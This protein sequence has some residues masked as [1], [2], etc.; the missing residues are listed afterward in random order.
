MGL[1][2]GQLVRYFHQL[3]IP[4]NQVAVA[5]ALVIQVPEVY[6]LDNAVVKDKTIFP[7]NVN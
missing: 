1:E 2:F 7:I 3:H 6:S 5:R 4:S